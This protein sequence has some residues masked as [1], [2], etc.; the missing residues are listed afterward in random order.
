MIFLEKL[1]A[2]FCTAIITVTPKIAQRF[3]SNKTFLVRNYC[4]LN[5]LS[6][7]SMPA[8]EE[9]PHDCLYV[10]SLSAERDLAAVIDAVSLV[11]SD[12]QVKLQLA[13]KFHSPYLL[14][15]LQQS[16]NWN[17]VNYLGYLDRQ[18]VKQQLTSARMGLLILPPVAHYKDSYPI[19]LFEYMAAGL[20]VIA[21]DF[22]VW[23]N[24][25]EHAKCGLLVDPLNKHAIAAA[26]QYL[27]AHPK[28]AKQMGDNGRKAVVQNYNWSNEAATLV[29]NYKK[30][31]NI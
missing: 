23:R 2:R 13:G 20:P 3:P 9:R 15:N 25:I 12:Y 29:Y 27:I 5:E 24:I 11:P 14:Q 16:P 21:S 31:L 17:N 19:K 1:A 4:D 30:I 18:Q 8:Y 10:G 26:I 28:A 6:W 22:P 7:P